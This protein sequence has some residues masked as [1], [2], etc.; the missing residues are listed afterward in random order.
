MRTGGGNPGAV[1]WPLRAGPLAVVAGFALQFR[2]PTR[3]TFDAAAVVARIAA[4]ARGR[5]DAD[6][7]ARTAGWER[8]REPLTGKS[9]RCA[10]RRRRSR[11]AEGVLFEVAPLET[12]DLAVAH[13]DPATAG[14]S[15][16]LLTGD[17]G[18]TPS[19]C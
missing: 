16:G 19:T 5:A 12:G 9:R 10:R 17:G 18:T 11:R 1:R 15:P 6:L 13:G 8:E 4:E 2:R 14:A 7:T 3:T